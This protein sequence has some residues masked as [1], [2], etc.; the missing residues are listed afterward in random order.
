M[1][2]EPRHP[3]AVPVGRLDD[4]PPLEREVIR[5]LRLWCA[6]PDGPGAVCA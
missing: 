5:C 1:S 4:L 2:A 3:G 6:G